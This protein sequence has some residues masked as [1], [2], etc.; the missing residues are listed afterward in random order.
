[1]FENADLIHR[2]T[3]ADAIRDGVLIDVS[4]TAREAGIRWP[5]ALTCAVWGRCVRVPAGVLGQDEVG[6]LWDVLW[7]LA[8]A[9][10]RGAGDGDEVRF[11]VHV[12]NDNR[13]RTPPLVWLKAVCGP[14]DDGEP[15]VTVMMPEEDWPK[16][17]ARNATGQ[18]RHTDVRRGRKPKRAFPTLR[19]LSASCVGGPGQGSGGAAGGLLAGQRGRRD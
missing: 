5:V 17:T 2:Y 10:R 3:R 13:E 14:G 19:L 1:M 8:C 15:V 6:R 4:A 11:S 18:G 16:G 9:A 12:R 7:L